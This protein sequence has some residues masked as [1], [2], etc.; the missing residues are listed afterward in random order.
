MSSHGEID[1]LI[2]ED[3]AADVELTLHVL[4]KNNL[5]NKIYVA[6]D[7]EEALDFIF[8]RGKFLDRSFDSPPRI[9]L[10]DLKLPKV[11]GKEV[12]KAVRND[13]RTRCIPIVIFTSSKEERDLIDGYGLGAN[14]F[15]QKPLDF[16]EFRDAVKQFGMYWLL[17]N[18]PAPANG[19]SSR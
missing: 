9:V 18:I 4:Q 2:V 3:N 7:G 14:S 6:R 19:L 8:C 16:N 10:L 13:P 5:A 1:I 17:V 11:N 12:L 15:V